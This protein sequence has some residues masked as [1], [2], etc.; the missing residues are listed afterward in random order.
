MFRHLL[1]VGRDDNQISIEP[2][3][4]TAQDKVQKC[5]P[6][7]SRACSFSASSLRGCGRVTLMT[8]LPMFFSAL[9]AKVAWR[10]LHQEC[11]SPERPREG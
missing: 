3:K 11:D 2:R 9:S 7:T 5:P 4:D 6:I 8:R 1:A 10:T